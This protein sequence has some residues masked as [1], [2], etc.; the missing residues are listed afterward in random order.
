MLLAK[1]PAYSLF[2][3][4]VAILILQGHPYFSQ[5][6][7]KENT[8]T[9]KSLLGDT[10]VVSQGSVAGTG[11]ISLSISIGPFLQSLSYLYKGKVY[12]ILQ[13]RASKALATCSG[14]RNPFGF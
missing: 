7:I 3:I 9:R 5:T 1:H 14:N 6:R 8:S 13:V 10:L 4:L 12:G 2:N 11:W